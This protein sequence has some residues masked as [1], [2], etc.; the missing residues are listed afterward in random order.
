MS[1]TFSTNCGSVDSLNVSVR[2]GCK[3][4]ACQIRWTDD[5]DTPAAFAMPRVLQC[6]ASAG[7]VSSV[8][9]TI[10]SIRSSPILRGAPHLGS[11]SMPLRRC[12]ANRSRHVLTVWRVTPTD[13]CDLAVVQPIG[14]AQNDLG[15]LRIGARDLAASDTSSRAQPARSALSLI[16]LAFRFATTASES[17]IGSIEIMPAHRWL[18][19]SETGRSLA[20]GIHGLAKVGVEGSNPFARSKMVKYFRALQCGPRKRSRS[21]LRW[22]TP[23]QHR[24]VPSFGYRHAEIGYSFSVS[25]T[26]A[27]LVLVGQD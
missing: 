7:F 10:S 6:V 3:Q 17:L 4:K 27:C 26:G 13:T 5:A 11:S 22:S 19:S 9:V 8:F 21:Y 15:P 16:L 18:E 12:F 25:N 2:C 1:R 24:G 20:L 23:G 14:R